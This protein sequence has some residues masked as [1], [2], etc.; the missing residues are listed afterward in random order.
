MLEGESDK[1]VACWQPAWHWDARWSRRAC[2]CTRARA[3]FGRA[4]AVLPPAVPRAGLPSA[5]PSWQICHDFNQHR[6]HKARSR[7]RK[8]APG[9]LTARE[10]FLNLTIK[11]PNHDI[12]PLMWI[13]CMRNLFC[14]SKGCRTEPRDH[15]MKMKYFFWFGFYIPNPCISQSPK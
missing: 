3:Y 11:W 10:M 2:T 12:F 6:Q 13:S 9:S 7:A 15:L 8:D 14:V 1:R 4:L 5:P